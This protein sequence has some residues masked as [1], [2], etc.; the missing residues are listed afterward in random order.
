VN[1]VKSKI[2]HDAVSAKLFIGVIIDP[3]LASQSATNLIRS[4]AG[5]LSP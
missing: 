5:L 4:P 3:S 1:A 2:R